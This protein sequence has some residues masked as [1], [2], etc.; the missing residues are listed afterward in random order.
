MSQLNILRWSVCEC[1]ISIFA[2]RTNTAVIATHKD[3]IPGYCTNYFGLNGVLA[4]C[5]IGMVRI[6]YGNINNVANVVCAD[7]VVNGT[8][9]IVWDAVVNK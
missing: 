4:A 8:L 2:I 5:G 6:V 7:F 1:L 9:A 3:P